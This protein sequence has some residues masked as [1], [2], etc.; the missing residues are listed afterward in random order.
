[1]SSVLEVVFS[2]F[3]MTVGLLIILGFIIALLVSVYFKGRTDVETAK[4]L[5]LVN[6]VEKSFPNE[7][8][9]ELLS[10]LSKYTE[11]RK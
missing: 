11:G 4:K 3:F 8:T 5:Y 6:L 10:I 2:N 9:S 7:W 1:M